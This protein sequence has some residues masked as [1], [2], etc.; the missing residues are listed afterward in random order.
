MAQIE[1]S[2]GTIAYSDTGGRG[3][4]IVL[5]HGLLMDAT[6]WDEVTADLSPGH[7]CV[8]PTLPLGA[9]TQAMQQYDHRA[10][11]AGVAVGDGPGGQLDLRH[12]HASSRLWRRKDSSACTAC[13][14]APRNV[15]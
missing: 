14:W 11:A 4:V 1:L 10:P 13:S 6:L 3:P 12:L 9:H 15:A 7:R 5:L 2:A 8:A